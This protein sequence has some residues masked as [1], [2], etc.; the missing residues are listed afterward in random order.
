MKKINGRQLNNTLYVKE[1]MS[2]S[3]DLPKLFIISDSIIDGN[4]FYL[5]IFYFEVKLFCLNR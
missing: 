1:I 2:I 5:G 4:F 3:T